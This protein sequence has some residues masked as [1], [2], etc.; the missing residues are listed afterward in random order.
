MDVEEI[1]MEIR[2]QE[3]KLGRKIKM[4]IVDYVQL[5]RSPHEPGSPAAGNYN[6]TRLRELA[7]EMN[8]CMLLLSQTSRSNGGSDGD[9]PIGLNSAKGSGAWEEQAHNVLTCWRPFSVKNTKYDWA[10]SV[11]MAKNRL[12]Q[13]KTVDLYFHGPSG[14]VRDLE[15]GEEMILSGLREQMEHDE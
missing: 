13:N 11:K 4:V 9:V 12:G 6:A 15:V 3:E 14:I 8:I 2:R 7:K 5:L 10:I 1:G